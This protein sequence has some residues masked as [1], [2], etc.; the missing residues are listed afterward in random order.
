MTEGAARDPRYAR[1][2]PWFFDRDDDQDDT[3]FYAY[4]RLVTHIDAPAI[5]A[6][7]S[8]YERMEIAGDV[9]DI[10]SSWVSHF[11]TQP[12]SLTVLGMNR[13][14]LDANPMA[15]ARVVHDL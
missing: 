5:D 9:L 2:P 15:T 7:G 11:R 10:M 14:E 3:E 4:P 1:F 12:R 13:I 8:F 6:V